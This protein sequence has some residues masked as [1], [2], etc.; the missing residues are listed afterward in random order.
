MSAEAGSPITSKMSVP[1]VYRIQHGKGKLAVQVGS[2]LGL[3]S[4]NYLIN[5]G[6]DLW[7]VAFL[8]A[9]VWFAL[10]VTGA[11]RML[12]PPPDVAKVSV[13]PT[14]VI[15]GLTDGKHLSVSTARIAWG[16]ITFTAEAPNGGTTVRTL[17]R[18]NYP[19]EMRI[20]VER[21][22]AS[23]HKTP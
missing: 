15:L 7:S 1:S 3:F 11:G 2:L 13:S 12:K 21:F 6:H 5:N 23:G 18:E 4:L 16:K 9:S 22:I 8:I 17:F 14:E 19:F 20:D 10:I